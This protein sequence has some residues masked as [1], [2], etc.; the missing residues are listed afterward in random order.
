MFG[1]AIAPIAL[2][3]A[4]LDQRGGTVTELG[5]VLASRSLAQVA[6]LLAGGVFADRFRRN[7]LMSLANLT[8]FASQGAVTA[9]F[10]SHVTPLLALM[11][12]SAVNGAAGALFI[13]ASRGIV[14]ELV[15]DERRQAANSL[16]R[17]SQSTS[18]ILGAAVAGLIVAGLGAGWG[19]GVDALSF[20]LSGILLSGASSPAMTRP[21]A[22]GRPN[23]FTELREGWAEFRSRS[24]VWTT[25][26]QFAVVNLC[27][28]PC[29]FVL[30]V[31]VA[32]QYLG[33][34][35]AWSLVVA[36]NAVGLVA[37]GAVAMKLKLRFPLRMAVLATFGFLPPFFLLAFGAPLW[38]LVA[39]MFVNGMCVDIFEVLWQTTLQTHIPADLLSRVASY[40]DM[41]SFFLGPLGL[42][43]IGPVAAAIGVTQTIAAGGSVL[44]LATVCSFMSPAVRNVSATVRPPSANEVAVERAK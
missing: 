34:P 27:F 39:A 4:I 28:R 11:A 5:L 22:R 23:F 35:K 12:F 8:A 21:S 33:G 36:A 37:G 6:F 29:V 2:S 25:V 42:I 40:D 38:L 24:W 16:M 18:T 7:R 41:G 32:K 9:M 3:F 14:P 30:G 19:I 15:P 44:L 43:L 1:T 26:S 10:L 13:P 20:L 31:V 17:L